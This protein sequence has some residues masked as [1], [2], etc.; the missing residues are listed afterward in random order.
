MLTMMT[1]PTWEK[2]ISQLL[3]RSFNFEK[4]PFVVRRNANEN[5]PE[6]DSWSLCYEPSVW[7]KQTSDRHNATGFANFRLK[8]TKPR[9]VLPVILKVPQTIGRRHDPPGHFNLNSCY[10]LNDPTVQLVQGYGVI[11]FVNFLL[12]NGRWC[13]N[14][15][16][17]ERDFNLVQIASKYT[18]RCVAEGK[19]T[20]V[21]RNKLRF[22]AKGPQFATRVQCEFIG[23]NSPPMGELG[24]VMSINYLVT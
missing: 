15:M 19:L 4:S 22:M 8:K 16:W 14:A 7:F 20:E 24:T 1:M 21:E 9:V 12:D 2:T 6:D 17:A 18:G 13:S 3:L 23:S 10:I 5:D 11:Y